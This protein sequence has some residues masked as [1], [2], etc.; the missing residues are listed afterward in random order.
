MARILLDG[1]AEKAQTQHRANPMRS[2][3]A[4]T[5]DSIRQRG[6]ARCCKVDQIVARLK[7]QKETGSRQSVTHARGAIPKARMTNRL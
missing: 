1:I 6:P 2:D 3:I 4:D 7:N 5:I